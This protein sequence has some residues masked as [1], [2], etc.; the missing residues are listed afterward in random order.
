MPNFARRKKNVHYFFTS[1][2]WKLTVEQN[3]HCFSVFLQ[4]NIFVLYCWRG[5]LTTLKVAK[6]NALNLFL[7][8]WNILREG[9]DAETKSSK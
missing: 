1:K 7:A 8:I 5:P 9:L 3:F 4:K 2:K 6:R